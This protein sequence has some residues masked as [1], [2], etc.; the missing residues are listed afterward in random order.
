MAVFMDHEANRLVERR[1]L[2]NDQSFV[3]LTRNADRIAGGG[4]IDSEVGIV[5]PELS[6][7]VCHSYDEPARHVWQHEEDVVYFTVIITRIRDAIRPVVV[8]FSEVHLRIC[9]RQY[10]FGKLTELAEFVVVRRQIRVWTPAGGKPTLC[11]G[12]ANAQLAK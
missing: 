8:K 11:Q 10:L 2:P 3:C 9:S 1:S 12:G 4:A 5:K 7:T 6:D